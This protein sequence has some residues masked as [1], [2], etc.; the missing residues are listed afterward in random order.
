MALTNLIIRPLVAGA[1]IYGGIEAIRNPQAKAA[2]AEPIAA[3]AV[4]AT[5]MD[6]EQLVQL[7]GAVQ[8]VAGAALAAGFL[9]R[10]AALVLAATLVPTTLAEHRF[11]ERGDG[12]E[13]GAQTS[14]FLKNLSMLGG[15]LSVATSTG[16]RPSLPWRARQALGSA[17]DAAG[18]T[19]HK[20]LPG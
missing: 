15:L 13:T 10:P 17:V 5:G 3:P 12:A 8:V 9:A 7:N 14:Q 4:D 20:V 2:A 6:T 19:V 16:G 11:W 1:F 18:D